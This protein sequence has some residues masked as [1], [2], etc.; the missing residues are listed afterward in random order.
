M[1]VG[2]N[3]GCQKSPSTAEPPKCTPRMGSSHLRAF[4]TNPK[5]SRA[6]Q[7]SP[8]KA[9]FQAAFPWEAGPPEATPGRAKPAA[10]PKGKPGLWHQLLPTQLNRSGEPSPGFHFQDDKATVACGP[11]EAVKAS[12]AAEEALERR[13][14]SLQPRLLHASPAGLSLYLLNRNRL[15]EAALIRAIKPVSIDTSCL[16]IKTQTTPTSCVQQSRSWIRPWLR[17]R[18]APRAQGQPRWGLLSTPGAFTATSLKIHCLG[19]QQRAQLVQHLASEAAG[20]SAAGAAQGAWSTEH[21][22]PGG[23]MSCRAPGTAAPQRRGKWAQ[24]SGT[25]HVTAWTRA[26]AGHQWH[27]AGTQQAGH[28]QPLQWLR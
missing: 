24:S 22:I 7:E 11:K 13:L 15:L 21:G 1:W 5:I 17:H 26:Q 6:H 4:E 20:G 28:E 18:T 8:R 2:A 12:R 14:R 16:S 9:S 10:A 19:W 25:Q 3:R 23:T 27:R